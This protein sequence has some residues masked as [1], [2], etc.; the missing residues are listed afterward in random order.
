MRIPAMGCAMVV[1]LAMAVAGCAQ[2]PPAATSDTG[3][4]AY[5]TPRAT[6]EFQRP[7]PVGTDT[8]SM[9]YPSVT[10]QGQTVPASQNYGTD[11]GNMAYPQPRSSGT[12]RQNTVR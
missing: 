8:G 11:T 6:G 7:A 12:I 5:P 2:N 9:A 1:G 4:M 10:R 3:N